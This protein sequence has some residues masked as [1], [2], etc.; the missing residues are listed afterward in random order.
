M[1]PHAGRLPDGNVQVA[2]SRVDDRLEQRVQQQRCHGTSD[3]SASRLVKTK[4]A[5]VTRF[6][7]P[8]AVN[9]E[10]RDAMTNGRLATMRLRRGTPATAPQRH[11][12]VWLPATQ[13][14]PPMHLA[15]RRPPQFDGS[16]LVPPP[17]PNSTIRH[18]GRL[19][20]KLA[21][22]QTTIEIQTSPDELVLLRPLGDP[23]DLLKRRDSIDD[24][25][26]PVLVQRAHPL[27]HR[28]FTN[29]LG[30]GTLERQFPD[31]GCH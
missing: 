17:L 26:Q 19:R 20:N 21:G 14:L 28:T 2:R 7:A 1:P 3:L 6:F 18:G 13:M 15:V 25:V 16:I 12:S 4:T 24:L 11:Y 8:A 9:R 23:H 30:W 5:P 31:F 27:S 29:V 10:C 22:S